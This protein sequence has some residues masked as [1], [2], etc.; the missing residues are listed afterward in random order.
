MISTARILKLFDYLNK[1][2]D[3][4]TNGEVKEIRKDIENI[5]G[6]DAEKAARLRK[7]AKKREIVIEGILDMR[8]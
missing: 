2:L 5:L 4:K 3:G 6:Y 1:H 8:I 7:E